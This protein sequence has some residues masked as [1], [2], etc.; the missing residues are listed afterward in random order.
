MRE[1]AKV[2]LK[3]LWSFIYCMIIGAGNAV[4]YFFCYHHVKDIYAQGWKL[5]V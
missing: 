4:L 2:F 3:K 1:Q 5:H